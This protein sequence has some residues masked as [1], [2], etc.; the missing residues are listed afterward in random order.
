MRYEPQRR[1]YERHLGQEYAIGL[2]IFR[3]RGSNLVQVA[4]AVLDEVRQSEK[5]DEMQGVRLFFL[6]DQ[7]AGVTSSLSELLKAGLMGALMSLVVLYLFLRNVKTTL[8]VAL[9]VP[10]SLTIA[11]GGLYAF[12]YSLNILTM[13]GLM[14]AVGMLVDNAVVVSESIFHERENHPELDSVTVSMKGIRAVALAVL[15]GTL[16]SMAVFLPNL[17]GTMNQLKIFLSHMAIAVCLSL[18][19]SW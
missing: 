16:T 18:L 13:M 15:A 19:A 7:A 12:G 9:S 6:E 5:S 17:F 14:L 3:E 2:E 11:L 10:I 4:D 8:M 1:N